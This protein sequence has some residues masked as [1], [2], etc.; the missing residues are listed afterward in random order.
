MTQAHLIQAEKMRALGELAAGMA[1]DF[2]NS[3][4]AAGE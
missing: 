2:N 3:L 1:H 4:C